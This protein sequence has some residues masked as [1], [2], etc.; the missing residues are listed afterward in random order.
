MISGKALYEAF[1][2]RQRELND[3]SFTYPP[4]EEQSKAIQ[5]MWEGIAGDANGLI[6]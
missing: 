6:R 4:F 5:N 2:E 1:W 3:E